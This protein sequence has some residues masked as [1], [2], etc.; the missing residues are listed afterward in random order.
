MHS[1]GVVGGFG[2]PRAPGGRP[3]VRSV[4]KPRAVGMGTGPQGGAEPPESCRPPGPASICPGGCRLAAS[5]LCS[6]GGSRW[7]ATPTAADG[8]AGSPTPREPQPALGIHRPGSTRIE[9][10]QI[11]H[12][13][14][15]F[16]PRN[17]VVSMETCSA[18]LKRRPASARPCPSGSQACS[19]ATPLTS[20][21]GGFTVGKP[22]LC[23]S[24]WGG[25][26]GGAAG[27]R[28]PVD[29]HLGSEQRPAFW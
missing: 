27:S 10:R 24:L 1:S 26:Q 22:Q 25:E 19:R 14:H 8:G 23:A 7:E 17:G 13:P 20:R 9:I 18:S 5:S 15:S 29:L 2:D 12:I 16:L 3:A 6:Q 11:L 21:G 4:L 28:L